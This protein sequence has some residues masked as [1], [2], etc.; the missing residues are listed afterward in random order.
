MERECERNQPPTRSA[1]R[2]RQLEKA[3]LSKPLI[4]LVADGSQL[5]RHQPHESIGTGRDCAGFLNAPLSS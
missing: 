3:N 5:P 1:W 2:R 4:T